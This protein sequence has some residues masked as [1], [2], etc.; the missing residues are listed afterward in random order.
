MLT[1]VKAL[2]RFCREFGKQI[3]DYYIFGFDTFSGL[4]QKKSE[5]D[6]HFSW[7]QGS[8][9]HKESDV[10]A[11]LESAGF[12]LHRLTL[13]K[14]DFENT[15]TD[16]L[17]NQLSD[18]PP[19]IVTV[20]CDYFSSAYTSLEWLRPMLI[21]G[22]FFYF[23]DIWSFHGNPNYGEL[24]AIREFNERG[25]GYLTSFPL[26]GLES[27]S[28]LYSNNPFEFGSWAKGR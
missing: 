7:N 28:Y 21:S 16:E 9:S 26:F 14:G 25:T 13:V 5:K 15:L 12:P 22:V 10:Q 3:T 27:Y 18:R 1:Y 24:A 8:F 19:A 20:D 23:D 17:R 4:P 6:D 2:Q 11:R